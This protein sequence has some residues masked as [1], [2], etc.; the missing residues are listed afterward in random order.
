VETS[1]VSA[2]ILQTPLRL[3]GTISPKPLLFDVRV[4]S[5]AF[6][7]ARLMQVA[8]NVNRTAEFQ[9]TKIGLSRARGEVHVTGEMKSWTASGRLSFPFASVDNPRL[10]AGSTRALTTDF[11]ARNNGANQFQISADFVAASAQGSSAK[12][13]K[14]GIYGN[15]RGAIKWNGNAQRPLWQLRLAANS[16]RADSIQ[17]GAWRA[18]NLKTLLRGGQKIGAQLSATKLAGR[19]AQLGVLGAR[20]LNATLHG[21]LSKPNDFSARVSAASALGSGARMAQ[22]RGVTW[23]SGALKSNVARRGANGTLQL[24]ADSLR[25]NQN[26][27]AAQIKS[28]KGFANWISARTNTI[29]STKFDAREANI[30]SPQA[31]KW[32]IAKFLGMAQGRTNSG[33]T[34]LKTDI[35]A[36]DF[37]GSQARYGYWKGEALRVAASTSD[38][39][40]KGWSGV[41][42]LGQTDVSRVNFAA[43]S[44]DMAA[45]IRDAGA[46]TGK[47][48]FSNLP[49]ANPIIKGR[50]RLTKITLKQNGQNVALQN[51]ETQIAVSKNEFRLAGLR[52]DSNFGFLQADAQSL[53]SG[54]PLRLSLVAPNLVLTSAQINPYLAA[55]GIQMQGEARGRLRVTTL[56]SSTNQAPVYQTQFDFAAPKA[57]LLYAPKNGANVPLRL[58]STHV[59]GKGNLQFASAKNWRFSGDAALFAAHLANGKNEEMGS[60][61]AGLQIVATGVLARD[62]KGFS[63]QLQGEARAAEVIFPFDGET[64]IALKTARAV[65]NAQPDNYQITRFEAVEGENSKLTGHAALRRASSDRFGVSGQVLAERFDAARIQKLFEN[66]QAKNSPAVLQSENRDASQLPQLGGTVFARADFSGDYFLNARKES[67]LVMDEVALQAR[68]YRGRMVW[69][70]T[71]V[72]IDVARLATTISLPAR[73]PIPIDQ[74]VIWSGGSRVS[75]KGVLSPQTNEAGNVASRSALKMDM[76]VSVNTLR[77]RALKNLSPFRAAFERAEQSGDL[78]GLLSGQFRIT[79]D[80][81]QPKI[82]GRAALKLAQAYGLDLEAASANV[83]LE[84]D[85]ADSTPGFRFALTDIAGRV[86]GT[87]FSGNLKADSELNNWNLDLKT[88]DKIATNRLLRLAQARDEAEQEAEENLEK[89]GP[90]KPQLGGLLNLPLRGELGAIL[91]LSGTL[92]G[93]DG[94]TLV[95]AHEGNVLVETGT[96]RWR[97][98]E[99]GIL[100]ADLRLQNG[101][102]QARQFELNHKS[103]NGDSQAKLQ[104]KGVLPVSLD[105][106]DLDATFTVENEELSF[107][108][109]IL[110]E[111]NSSLGAKGQKV[112]YLDA[113]LKRLQELPSDIEGRFDLQAQLE[114]SWRVPVVEVRSL[115]AREVSFRNRNGIMQRLPDVS[116]RFI[117]DG[118]DNGAVAIQ[119]A[120]LRLPAE[121]RDAD[122]VAKNADEESDGDDEDLLIRTLRPGRIVPGGELS[123]TA[124]ILNADLEKIA[125][126]LPALRDGEGGAALK[127]RLSDF[128]LQVAGTTASPTVTGSLQGENW[129]YKQYSLDRVRLDR[130]TISDGFLKVEPGFLTAVKGEFQSAAAWGK[131]PWTWGDAGE[132]PG[133]S[134]TR[135]MKI[136]LPVGRENF[137]AL[138]GIF[139]PQLVNVGA[140]EFAGEVEIGGTLNRPRLA[141]EMQIKNGTFRVRSAMAEFDI[142]VAGLNGNLKFEDGNRLQ[143][144]GAG[145]SGSLVPAND[146]KAPTTGNPPLPARK[147]SDARRKREGKPPKLAGNFNLLGNVAFNLDLKLWGEPRRALSAHRY[148]LRMALNNGLYATETFSGAREI[149]A[150]AIWKTGPGIPQNSQQLKWAISA[151]GEGK[152]KEA[153]RIVS[154]A[155]LRLSPEFAVSADAFFRARGE[156]FSGAEDFVAAPAGVFSTTLLS[157][158]RAAEGQPSMVKFQ[159]FRFAWKNVARG[160]LKGDLTLDNGAADIPPAPPF[161]TPRARPR[162]YEGLVQDAALVRGGSTPSTRLAR[163]NVEDDAREKPNFDAN[164]QTPLRVAGSIALTRAELFGPPAMSEA[165]D[166]EDAGGASRVKGMLSRLPDAPRFDVK[167]VA[168][169]EVQFVSSNLRAT[170]SGD[171]E[172]GG[173]PRDPVVFGTL[174]TKSGSITFPNARARLDNGEITITARRD[175]SADVLRTRVEIDA[176]ARGRSGRYEFTIRLRG[177]LDT[178]EASTQDLRVDISSNPALSEDEAFAQLLGTAAFNRGGEEGQTQETYARAIVGILSGPLFSGIERT[179]ER[180]FGLTTIALDYRIDEPLGIEV[181]KAIGERLFISYRRALSSPS[182]QKTPFNLRLEYRVKGDFQLGVETDEN[183]TRRFTLEKRWRF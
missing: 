57:G 102:L 182:G 32:R 91:S 74:L 51:I 52:A 104:V 100:N 44:P 109:E 95:A 22:L 106:P 153:G 3:A 93:E 6:D 78:D 137:G 64:K 30:Q 24:S 19:H 86:E 114:Q 125:E 129:Q 66:W 4:A 53:I 72:P 7:V 161:A 170:I 79:G 141:G 164:F 167:L 107:V 117:Y 56:A 67:P 14:F 21:D 81:Q 49:S 42:A 82:V 135:P 10:G 110:E 71:L 16:A 76:D 25:A 34:S 27:N 62:A 139:V 48:R 148:D 20:D 138:A 60:R 132:A 173:T 144:E 146:V 46:V 84:T 73:G 13:G 112:A 98:R 128:V 63:P 92:R 130:F 50:A 31:G 70:K 168:G 134:L 171:V 28:I 36:R 33:A 103:Q 43:L 154:I 166:D 83:L 15:V 116:A 11:S 40:R 9:N 123:L 88:D 99:L 178:G 165:D 41:M 68:L 89:D 131:V 5:N 118:N 150:A 133:V 115:Q 2:V 151:S 39:T 77:V 55:S 174:F 183:E 143:I 126:W 172:V 105:T 121:A 159:D 175:P 1:G 8:R 120:E 35:E 29:F 58:G 142:G 47:A 163:Q 23:Q 177:P 38:A 80:T 85:R 101:V 111:I 65:F 179:L 96:L 97:G 169:Q 37:S 61:V 124:E 149:N 140:D 90:P 156:N 176:T 59:R 54:G 113:I 94:A 108:L 18:E 136:H 155:A 45:R 69:L 119:S 157:A 75:A 127:G 162:F 160:S 158:L 26:Q 152:E 17:A 181:G 12:F 122:D 147:A 145:L 180:T 87:R